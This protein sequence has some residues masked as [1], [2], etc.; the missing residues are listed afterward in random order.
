MS[1]SRMISARRLTIFCLDVVDEDARC[2]AKRVYRVAQVAR[3][4]TITG[5]ATGG[6]GHVCL[7]LNF[8]QNFP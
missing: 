5:H 6:V 7:N 1:V 8:R 3:C 2:Y 4:E